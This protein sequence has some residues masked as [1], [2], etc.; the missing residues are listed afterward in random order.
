LI[1]ASIK[2]KAFSGTAG[3]YKISVI[4]MGKGSRGMFPLSSEDNGFKE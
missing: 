4:I 3:G 2:G 1:P